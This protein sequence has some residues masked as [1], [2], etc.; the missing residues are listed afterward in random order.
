MRYRFHVHKRLQDWRL[1][2]AEGTPPPAGCVIDEWE[3]S[4]TREEEDTNAE[5]R[6]QVRTRGFVLFKLGGDFSDVARE[7]RERKSD[8]FYKPKSRAN[9][10]TVFPIHLGLHAAAVREPEFTGEADWY[11]AYEARHAADGVEGRLVSAFTFGASWN[12]WEMHPH[13]SEVV[14]C[15]AGAMT[16]VQELEGKSVRTPLEAGEY[17]INP[18]GVWHTADVDHS[19]TAVFITAGVGTQN[20][21]R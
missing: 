17:A 8:E 20:R 11:E 6:E 3:H 9:P 1:V 15:T 7:L 13:G 18:P 2:T 19:A 5:V 12:T 10:L 16:L 14:L 4:R 21:A